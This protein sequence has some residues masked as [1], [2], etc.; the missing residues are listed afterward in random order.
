MDYLENVVKL[1]EPD[2][3]CPVQDVEWNPQGTEFCLI[4]GQTPFSIVLCDKN[5]ALIHDFGK[6]RK[7]TIRYSPS[8]GRFMA[9]GG[10]GNLAGELEFVDVASKQTFKATR[11]ECTVECQWAPNGQIF[12]TS[13]THPRM[14]VDN[15]ISLFRYSGE[16]VAKLDFP[17][18]YA[19]KWRPMPARSFPDTP[20][21]P[22]AFELGKSEPEAAKKAYRPPPS[23]PVTAPPP[24]PPVVAPMKIPCPDKDWHYKDPQGQVHGP[25]TRS[26]MNSWNKA[27]YF[28]PELPIRAGLVLPFVPLTDLFPLDI[29]GPPFEQ[30][31]VV[32]Q[33]WIQFK[34]A[35]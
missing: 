7:N 20:A 21:S 14:R 2:V 3:F 27:G 15:S 24:P 26:V 32:P 33:A 9:L 6:A 25:Y 5:G 22:R 35:S 19:S 30:A 28:K 29:I 16:L 13:S 10:F 1:L 34:A 12:M 23:I 17:E 31:M 8:Y 18:L 11:S 4:Y